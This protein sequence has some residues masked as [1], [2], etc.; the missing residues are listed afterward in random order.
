M[1]KHK[2]V[3]TVDNLEKQITKISNDLGDI[4]PVSLK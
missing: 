3:H 1:D 2:P 4:S